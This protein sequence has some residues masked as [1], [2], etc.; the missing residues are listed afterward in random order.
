MKK[1]ILTLAAAMLVVMGMSAQD[2]VYDTQTTKQPQ[3]LTPT[4]VER[5]LTKQER[6]RLQEQIDSVQY[7][8]AMQAIRDTAF[9]LE[10]SRVVFKYGQRAYV[11]THTNFISVNKDKAV[12]QVAFNIPVAGPNGMG[13]ITLE[14]TPSRYEIKTDKKGNPYISFFVQGIAI[15]SQVFINMC[16]GS[17][18]ATVTI[19]PNFHSNRITLEG[20]VL[21][22]DQSFVIQGRTI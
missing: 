15:S 6:K 13:G 4:Q 18:E 9:T 22:T 21:P 17:N 1:I 5:K 8:Q 11:N 3:T 10:A 20:V 7:E 19:S 14:G 2:D 12:V 16:K